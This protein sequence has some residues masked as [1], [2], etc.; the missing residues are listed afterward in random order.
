MAILR[1]LFPANVQFLNEKAFLCQLQSRL[2]GKRSIVAPAVGDDLPVT[3]QN[4]GNL[5]QFIR[6]STQRSGN[7]SAGEW[8]SAT[9]VEQNEIELFILDRMEYRGT[10]PF[11]S[12]FLRK[13]I[14]I[15]A[16][17]I[18]CESHGN[19]LYTNSAKC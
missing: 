10:R 1:P 11:G 17:F 12:Q 18:R 16:N 6:G 19:L 2:R 5:V 9:R 15:G 7:M 14:T 3:R 8:F 13:I 4:A